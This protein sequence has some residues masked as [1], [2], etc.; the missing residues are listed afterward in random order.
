VVAIIAADHDSAISRAYPQIR[1]STFIADSAQVI[2]D[3]L[4]SDRDN[5]S[6]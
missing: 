4:V 2:D 5:L 3:L 1:P 6:P